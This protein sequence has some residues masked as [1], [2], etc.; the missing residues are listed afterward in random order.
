MHICTPS[1]NSC[2]KTRNTSTTRYSKIVFQN[3]SVTLCYSVTVI[4][5]TAFNPILTG[6]FE[7]VGVGRGWKDRKCPPPKLWLVSGLKH[8]FFFFVNGGSTCSFTTSEINAWIRHLRFRDI[9][10]EWCQQIDFLPPTTLT[11]LKNVGV[12]GVTCM[13]QR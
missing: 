12:S 2:I 11:R 6:G 3:Q 10:I 13:V 4:A 9:F 5:F 1:L 7:F 8:S